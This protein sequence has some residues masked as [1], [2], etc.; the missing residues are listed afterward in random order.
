MMAGMGNGMHMA[1]EDATINAAPESPSASPNQAAL[2][3]QA[4]A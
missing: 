2:L 1:P 4:V 3:P